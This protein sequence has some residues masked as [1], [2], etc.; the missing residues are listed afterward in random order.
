MDSYMNYQAIHWREGSHKSSTH[1][2]IGE[3]P[4]SIRV[5]GNPYSVVMRTPGDEI[6]HVA[7]F[8]LGEGMAD[9]HD[10]IETIAFCDGSDTNVVAV[11]LPPGRV[12][13]IPEFLERR[14][15]IS[16]TSYGLCGK[17]MVEELEQ[18]IHPVVD[19]V[20]VDIHKALKEFNDPSMISKLEKMGLPTGTEQERWLSMMSIED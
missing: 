14:N 7:G 15:F 4:L 2:L 8:C 12:E 10:D 1:K 9:H 11:T 6:A 17:E 5:Q 18:T 20:E 3:E 13:K 19:D 16:Q